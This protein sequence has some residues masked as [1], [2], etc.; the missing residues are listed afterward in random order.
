MLCALVALV[1]VKPVVDGLL[2]PG[3]AC[4]CAQVLQSR[5]QIFL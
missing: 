5:L 2:F 3:T 4:A 1:Y